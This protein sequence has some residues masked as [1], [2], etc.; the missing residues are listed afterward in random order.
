M[1]APPARPHWPRA[2]TAGIVLCVLLLGG[3]FALPTDPGG[4][5]ER[6]LPS[7]RATSSLLLDAASVDG[8]MVAVGERGHVLL[9]TDDGLSW[10]QIT[11]PTRAT[12]T[13]VFLLNDERGWAVGHDAVILRTLD[14]GR[15][16]ERVYHAPEQERPLLD[17]W[18]R[19]ARHGFAI[20]AYGFFLVT[21]DGGTSWTERQ[22][23]DEDDFHLNHIAVSDTG[24]L[25]LAA[26][27]G[28]IYRSEDGGKSWLSLPSPYQGSFF[29][30]LPLPGDALL[31]MGLRGHLFR[32]EDAGSSWEEIDTTTHAMLTDALHL[33]DG[34]VLITGLEGVLLVSK[35][36]GRRFSLFQRPDRHGLATALQA[37]D[38]TLVLFGE[39]GFHRMSTDELASP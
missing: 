17:V 4:A 30:T 39:S 38:S 23:S 20:G 13:G 19:D 18:F 31:V 21:T 37:S 36:G 3:R 12:L 8:L 34:S 1:S 27:A 25:Y 6:S 32:S 11:V 29:A 5:Q 14:G 26:E 28:T 16:W 15:S 35:D 10:T 2:A 33:R 7:A 9:S 24:R 22:V